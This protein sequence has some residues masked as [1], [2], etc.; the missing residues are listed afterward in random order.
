MTPMAEA[1][2]IQPSE[3]VVAVFALS[4]SINA[5]SDWTVRLNLTVDVA[6]GRTGNDLVWTYRLIKDALQANVIVGALR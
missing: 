1:R 3:A 2:V 5:A 4:V 6:N